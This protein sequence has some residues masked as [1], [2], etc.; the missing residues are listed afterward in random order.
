MTNGI[1]FAVAGKGTGL[2]LALSEYYANQAPQSLPVLD[3]FGTFTV[4]GD[5]SGGCFND[6]H[7]VATHPALAT[8]TDVSLS[9]WQCS[10]HEAFV[11]YPQGSGSRDFKPLAIA[12]NVTGP[13]SKTFTDHSFGIPYILATNITAP[14]CQLCIPFPGENLCHP[15]TACSFTPFGDMCLTR[16]GFKADGAADD[17]LRVQWRMNWPVPGHEHRVAV[18]PGTSADTLCDSK[19]VGQDV[20]KEVSIADCGA[21]NVDD[22]ESSHGQ[23]D[24]KVMHEE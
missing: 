20:C 23:A 5:F 1:Q 15:T 17:D 16:P 8:L 2:Y 14:T 24:Q 9:N 4:R 13:G 3:Q 11:D 19:H 12:L 21:S 6:V 22:V 18:F 7:I 10:I